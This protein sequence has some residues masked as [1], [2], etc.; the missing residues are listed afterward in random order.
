MDFAERFTF[1]LP[2]MTVFSFIG[3]PE[4]GTEY[5]ESLCF[6]RLRLT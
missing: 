2:A 6:D 5:L 1:P 3:F 4:E